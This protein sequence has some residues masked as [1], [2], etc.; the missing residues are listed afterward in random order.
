MFAPTVIG[1]EKFPL[2][3][4]VPE[5]RRVAQVLLLKSSMLLLASDVPLIV[6]VLLL[7]GLKGDD[8]ATIG[9][10]TAVETSW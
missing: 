5:A 8:D 2:P 10:A 4:A 7:E 6:V 9:T 1:I 3:F